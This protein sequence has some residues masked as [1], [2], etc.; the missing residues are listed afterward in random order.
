M[1]LLKLQT[2]HLRNVAEYEFIFIFTIKIRVNV[3]SRNLQ[4]SK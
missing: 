4:L 2:T 1:R 3:K